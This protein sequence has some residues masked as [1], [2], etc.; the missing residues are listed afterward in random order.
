MAL[1]WKDKNGR[2]WPVCQCLKDWLTAYENEALRR[3]YIKRSIDLFQTIGN[4]PASAGYHKGGGN[5]DLA[6]QSTDMLRLA[7]NM[8]GA[9]FPRDSRD[10]MSYHCHISLK[11]CPHMTAGPRAQVISLENGRNGLVNNRAD[12]GPRTGIKWPL[13]TFTQG[14][15]WAKAEAA[16]QPVTP[17]PPGPP[18]D[19]FEH[20]VSLLNRNARYWADA[21]LK[22]YTSRVPALAAVSASA[23]ASVDIG[24][25]VGGYA[26]GAAYNKAR[27]WGATDGCR[28][29]SPSR[30]TPTSCMVARSLS[31][32]VS[33]STP[34][35]RKYVATGQF[36][37]AGERN[38]WSTWA[39][40]EDIK[41]GIRELVNANHLEFEPKGTN[42]S[43]HWGNQRRFDQ[44]DAAMTQLEPIAEKYKVSAIICAGD[45]N[46]LKSD[47]DD[48][49]GRAAAKH[50]Y[51]EVD[52]RPHRPHL[53]QGQDHRPRSHRHQGPPRNRPEPLPRGSPAAS[54]TLKKEHNMKE[55]QRAYVYRVFLALIPLAVIYGVV[56][57]SDVAVWTG[58]AAALLSTGLATANTSTKG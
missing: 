11:G 56:Q 57:E 26:D 42:V 14:I 18:A 19:F 54:R 13:R 22:S 5:V 15:A 32:R 1:Y 16:G 6:Q 55:S 45:M 2:N 7:R 53:R 47:V 51:T 37:T 52:D 43:G 48:G 50:G 8:G 46:G 33:T 38:R 9:A 3:G 21:G 39:V 49:P 20:R 30:A 4:A 44:L 41:T 12:R 25:E 40:L 28:T 34:N 24:C 31:P 36:E 23:R 29:T 17:K 35:K 58:L 10:G 27:G